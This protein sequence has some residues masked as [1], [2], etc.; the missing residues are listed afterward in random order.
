MASR[1]RPDPST[2][3]L[4]ASAQD[5]GSSVLPV[6]HPTLHKLLRVMARHQPLA[7]RAMLRSFGAA[8]FGGVR[9]ACVEGAAGR[10]VERR[11]ELALQ[12]DALALLA[13]IDARPRGEQ[14]LR[15]GM[16]PALE[17]RLLRA[18]LGPPASANH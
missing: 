17:E 6:T 3:A 1:V 13:E 14:G 15:V 8:T 11:G 18:L 4:R 2:T 5:E 16:G 9:A 10:R 12:D 7:D